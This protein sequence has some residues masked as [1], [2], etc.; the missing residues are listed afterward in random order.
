MIVNV[1]KGYLPNFVPEFLETYGTESV[2]VFA[3]S[4][5]LTSILAE[6]LRKNKKLVSEDTI[7]Y[8]GTE[9]A[10]ETLYSLVVSVDGII[11]LF[12]EACGFAP[13]GSFSELVDSTFEAGCFYLWLKEFENKRFSNAS[14]VIGVW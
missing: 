3:A 8:F 9:E 14:K 5:L 11:T 12:Q 4:D 7:A 1:D 6:I 13:I 10:E 2:F